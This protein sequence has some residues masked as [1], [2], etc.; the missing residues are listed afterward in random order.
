ML[1][2]VRVFIGFNVTLFTQFFVGTRGMP[3]R[4]ATYVDEFHL[5]HQIST[6]GSFILATGFF[7]HLFTFIHSLVAGKPAPANPW[8]GLTLEWEVESPPIEHNFHETP[9][10]DT[11]PYNFP[12][13][14]RSAAS[15]AHH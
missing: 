15:G 6:V 10:V 9:H 13:I 11:D 1:G 2:A 7:V 14:D 12:E 4:Y 3:R 5:L 8:G